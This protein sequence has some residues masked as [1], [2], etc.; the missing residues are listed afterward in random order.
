M[1]YRNLVP[2]GKLRG[3]SDLLHRKKLAANDEAKAILQT[4]T[5][6]AVL[7]RAD[8]FFWIPGAPIQKSVEGL[9]RGLVHSALLGL[10]RC[11]GKIDAIKHVCGS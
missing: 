10:S 9:L 2:Y 11:V 6:D 4:W 5:A 7:L 8:H 3:I 1:L